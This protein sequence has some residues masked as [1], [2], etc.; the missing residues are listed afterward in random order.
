[1]EPENGFYVNR[2][3]E[4]TKIFA[5]LNYGKGVHLKIPI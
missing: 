1:M 3:E 4:M 2:D 5:Y